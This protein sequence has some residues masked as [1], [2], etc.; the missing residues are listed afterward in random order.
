MNSEMRME[1]M[2][3]LICEAIKDKGQFIL[4]PKGTSMLPTIKPIEDCIVLVEVDKLE[5]NDIILYKRN[6]GTFVV[7]RIMGMKNGNYILCGDNQTELEHGIT[8][9]Q[10]IAKVSQIRKN[11]GK[12]LCEKDIRNTLT[13]FRLNTRRLFMKIKNTIKRLLYPAYKFLFKRGK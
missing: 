8:K 4:H 2:Y 5:K 10:I 7:H 13:V 3:P 6:T 9:G 11:G 1:D 12:I